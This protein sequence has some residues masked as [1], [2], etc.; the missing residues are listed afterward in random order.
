MLKPILA[1]GELHMI[2]ATTADEYRRYFEKEAALERR[3]RPVPVIEPSV[4]DAISILRERVALDAGDLAVTYENPD[5]EV[6]G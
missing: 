5:S 2:S 1:R 4:E 3:F 6:A